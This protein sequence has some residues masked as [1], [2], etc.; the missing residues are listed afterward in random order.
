M[1]LLVREQ[2]KQRMQ[3]DYFMNKNIINYMKM[4]NLEIAVAVAPEQ[5]TAALVVA[6]ARLADH[7]VNSSGQWH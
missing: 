2:S 7:L 6:L 5:R 4:L 1:L 3:S